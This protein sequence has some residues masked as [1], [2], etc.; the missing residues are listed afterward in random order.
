[1]YLRI[2]YNFSLCCYT[3]IGLII[4][5]DL[6]DIFSFIIIDETCVFKILFK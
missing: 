5:E 6:S 3:L 2:I 1:M 4:V